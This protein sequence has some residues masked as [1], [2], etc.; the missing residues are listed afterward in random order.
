LASA[1]PQFRVYG[2]PSQFRR[3]SA[4]ARRAQSLPVID[5]DLISESVRGKTARD[6]RRKIGVHGEAIPGFSPGD[7]LICEY[8]ID[9]PAAL[10]VHSFEAS[11]VW[12]TSGKGDTDIGVHFFERR[13][14]RSLPDGFLKQV[15]RLS[16]V[17]PKTPLS[18]TGRIVQVSWCVRI[19]LFMDDNTQMTEDAPFRLGN[20][21]VCETLDGGDASDQPES[22]PQG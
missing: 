7:F 2:S 21:S 4:E 15:Q 13:L 18:Y 17:L 19:R 5:I 3:E 1:T 6:S 20:A 8:T 22:P 14:T 10:K 16:T 9:V 12:F 11:V